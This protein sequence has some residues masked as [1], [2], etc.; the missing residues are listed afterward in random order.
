MLAARTHLQAYGNQMGRI[1]TRSQFRNWASGRVE[2][3]M[4]T[5]LDRFPA[6]LDP[7][8]RFF[9]FLVENDQRTHLDGHFETILEHRQELWTPFLD[10]DFL[11]SVLSVPAD[12]GMGH[13]FYDRWFRTLAPPVWSVPWQTYPGHVPCPVPIPEDL[14]YQWTKGSQS[15]PSPPAEL[16]RWLRMLVH[17]NFPAAAFSRPMVLGKLVLH[18]LR[19]REGRGWLD[20]VAT[21]HS[22]WDRAGHHDSPF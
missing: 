8:R 13:R 19:I 20:Q 4:Q 12:A 6:S 2:A 14:S 9:L 16:L 11:T 21:L 5:E 3:A 22:Y 18:A 15:R 10:G 17:G 1:A 7:A